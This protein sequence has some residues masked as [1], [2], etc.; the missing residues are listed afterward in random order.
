MAQESFH[1]AR[2]CF[3]LRSYDNKSDRDEALLTMLR[4]E[5][6]NNLAAGRDVESSSCDYPYAVDVF[7]HC[8][9]MFQ[10]SVDEDGVIDDDL[11]WAQD[12]TWID[13]D[14]EGTWYS[15]VRKWEQAGWWHEMPA[16]INS[17]TP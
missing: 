6:A 17:L 9:I 4:M 8:A 11:V 14:A 3:S 7:G 10:M 2:G 15:D 1:L 13:D 16:A 5:V 12:A